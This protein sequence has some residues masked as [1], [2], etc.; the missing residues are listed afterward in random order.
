M[1]VYG[2]RVPW[3]D[4]HW[5]RLQQGAERLRLRVPERGL[6]EAQVAAL[7]AGTGDGVLKLIV[8]R[9]EGTRGY[10]PGDSP[11]PTWVLSRHAP[12]P[13][14]GSG[15]LKLRWCDIR[16]ATQPLLAGLKHCNRLEQVLARAEWRDLR[17]PEA[18]ADEGL[19]RSSDGDVVCATAANM[20]VLRA[21]RWLTPRTDRC[22]VDGVCRGWAMAMLEAEPARLVDADIEGA[23]AVFLCNA[24][25]G[26]LPVA[27]LGTR[28]WAHHPQVGELQRQL[29]AEHPAFVAIHT[30]LS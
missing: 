7:C 4:A 16:L 5:S 19:M 1:R 23:D 29:A 15:G 8:S 13:L 28:V 20:F 14:P 26:I 24:V 12:P 9:G 6:V 30:E 25:R 22:G 17:P 11:V 21:G 27:R 2:G 18:D 3:W 10:A